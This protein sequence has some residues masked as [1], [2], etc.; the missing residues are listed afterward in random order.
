MTRQISCLHAFIS[1]TANAKAAGS[2][3]RELCLFVQRLLLS[4][5]PSSSSSA[6]SGFWRRGKHWRKQ[7]PPQRMSCDR[8]R[9]LTFVSQQLLDILAHHPHLS[10]HPCLL[11][12]AKCVSSRMM[13]NSMPYNAFCRTQWLSF[14]KIYILQNR[15][16]TT[17]TN[18]LAPAQ[19]VSDQQWL[20]CIDAGAV[21]GI[22]SSFYWQLRPKYGPLRS[23]MGDADNLCR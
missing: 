6:M 23:L 5:V 13:I 11:A 18:P 3:I 1:Y 22:L 9:S 19:W 15:P 17:C 12:I 2:I 8:L 14:T 7:P 20:R 4:S 10:I 21:S 16:Y